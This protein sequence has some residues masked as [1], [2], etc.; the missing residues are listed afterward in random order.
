M[1]LVISNGEKAEVGELLDGYTQVVA[2][3]IFGSRVKGN[4]H[5]D[6]DLDVAL[7]CKNKTEIALLEVT[8]KLQRILPNFELD[9]VAVDLTNDPLFLC[10]IINGTV[11]YEKSFFQRA[12]LESKAVFLYEDC[13][14]IARI[15]KYYLDKSF[16]E[17]TYAS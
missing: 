8:A 9:V 5:V 16:K 4:N 13:K 14:K 2:G 11:I 15:K 17:G 10:Q 7:F 3:Y 12:G 1:N 6:S